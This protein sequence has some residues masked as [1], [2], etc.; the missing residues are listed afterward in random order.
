MR[1]CCQ[2]EVIQMAKTAL[3]PNF[4]DGG[5]DFTATSSSSFLQNAVKVL[6]NGTFR[7]NISMRALINCNRDLVDLLMWVSVGHWV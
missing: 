1:C 6:N 7:I 2:V 3:L 4:I 5:M